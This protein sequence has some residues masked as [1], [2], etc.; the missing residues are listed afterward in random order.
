MLLLLSLCLWLGQGQVSPIENQSATNANQQSSPQQSPVVESGKTGE[1]GN[2]SQNDQGKANRWSDPLVFLNLALF[3]AVL[4]QAAIYWKQ[5]REMRNSLAVLTRQADAQEM[6]TGAMQG[7]LAAIEKQAGIMSD[8]LTETR[9]LVS[10][11]ERAVK[12]A[13]DSVKVVEQNAIDAQ[14]AY[15]TVPSGEVILLGEDQGAA[16]FSL[17]LVNSGN[18]PAN[19]VRM[20][21]LAAVRTEEP[22]AIDF[23]EAVWV[24]VGVIAPKE[25]AIR[26]VANK[27]DITKLESK[28]MQERKMNLYVWGA[29]EYRD[30]FKQ[31]RQTKFC[32]VQ[33][34]GSAKIGPCAGKNEAT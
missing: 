11:N 14:R 24:A 10:Q 5:L 32:Y 18:T 9:K 13:E 28:L 4:I 12:A 20:F 3:V 17:N 15:V 33:R 30:V 8:G 7:Q 2:S 25:K 6:Q 29:I 31:L 21:A 27:R 16:L 19:E 26:L 22:P 1:S 23:R 34:F